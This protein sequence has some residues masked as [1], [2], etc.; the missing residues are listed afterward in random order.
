MNDLLGEFASFICMHL[1]YH[2]VRKTHGTCIALLHNTDVSE[3]LSKSLHGAHYK[4]V[5]SPAFRNI[6]IQLVK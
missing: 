5:T 6:C 4:A 3:T 2:S 1:L